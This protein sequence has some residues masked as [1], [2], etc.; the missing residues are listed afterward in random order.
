M[1]RAKKKNICIECSAVCCHNLALPLK[2]PRT[3]YDRYLLRWKLHFDTV[4]IYIKNKRWHLLVKGKCMYLGKDTM[5]TNYEHRPQVC[6]D[7]SSDN[8]EM[9]GDWY[10][11]MI[12]TPE[13]F[14]QY[15]GI[16]YKQIY[17]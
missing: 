14:D 17:P 10:D 16:K 13:E 9:T 1:S 3:S 4:S 6:R 8:C 2:K 5:C 12:N 15:L 7:H 11:V